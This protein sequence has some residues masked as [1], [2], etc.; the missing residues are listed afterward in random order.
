MSCTALT[1]YGPRLQRKRSS[2][3][4]LILN[5]S[6]RNGPPTEPAHFPS[7]VYCLSSPIIKR[8][9]PGLSGTIACIQSPYANMVLNIHLANTKWPLS[10]GYPYP[11]ACLLVISK[12]PP[13]TGLFWKLCLLSALQQNEE[14]R[15]N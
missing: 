14:D 2:S 4:T 9:C 1:K 7:H 11:Q 3:I 13:K 15:S 5:H 6:A 8:R 12:S 10:R